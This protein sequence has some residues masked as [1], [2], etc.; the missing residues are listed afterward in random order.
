VGLVSGIL[1]VV[2]VELL[3]FKLHIDDPVGAVAVH[4]ACGLFGT[5]C[6]GLFATE[7]FSADMGLD[8]YGLFYGGGFKLL[9]LQ[10][11]GVI[12]IALWTVGLMTP[13]FLLMKKTVG[14]RV[15]KDDEIKGLDL[16]E[17]GLANAYAGFQTFDDTY[18]EVENNE[19]DRV[20]EAIPVILSDS[21]TPNVK[22]SN[23]II[24]CRENKFETLKNA[25][26]KIEITGMTVTRVMGCGVQKGFTEKWRGAEV[27]VTL[28]PKIQ[29]EVVVSKIPVD[30]VIE[31][32]RRALFTGNLGDGKIFVYNVERAVKVR[33][34]E[35]NYDALQDTPFTDSL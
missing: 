5:I 27:G 16:T 34:G 12:T 28:L 22:M 19:T 17:H 33:T 26:S 23:V 13:I 18:E 4:G 3:D 2:V 14:L 11:L 25:L 30:L 6:V 32:A 21:T 15:S 20:E 7:E 29:V 35:Q 1:V 8:N 24:L 10:L 31:T 9:G